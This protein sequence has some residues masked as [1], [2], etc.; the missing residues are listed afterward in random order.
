MFP[1]KFNDEIGC[2]DLCF[3]SS[4]FAAVDQYKVSFG[5]RDMLWLPKLA[6]NDYCDISL[7]GGFLLLTLKDSQ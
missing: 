1:R 3:Y 4:S 6:W 5:S 7:D 2:L